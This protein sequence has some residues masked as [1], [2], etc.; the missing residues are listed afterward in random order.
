MAKEAAKES[1]RE[2]QRSKSGAYFTWANDRFVLNVPL[3]KPNNGENDQSWYIPAMNRLWLIVAVA[4]LSTELA[5]AQTEP[6]LGITLQTKQQS[7]SLRE[8][9]ELIIVRENQGR[10]SLLVPRQW[11]WGVMRTDIRL[12]D[13]KGHEVRTDFLA[14]ELPP[15][16][17][18]YDFVL[19]EPRQFLG[20]HVRGA[21]KE[22][23][24]IPGEYEFVVEY[25]SYLSEHYAREV[26]KM[27]NEPFWSRERGTVTSNRIK[28][29][30]TELG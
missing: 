15:P 21:A 20:T 25:T 16:P 26:M 6:K 14:D 11:G 27:P 22:F 18:P 2:K 9:I 19:L 3:Y 30:V 1:D 24:N 17:Q 7:Y 23:V 28:V 12:F 29:R 13:A 4:S 10:E 8:E 5:S